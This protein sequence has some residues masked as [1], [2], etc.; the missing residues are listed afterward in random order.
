[1]GSRKRTRILQAGALLSEQ[2]ASVGLTLASNSIGQ[3]GK[4]AE[5]DYLGRQIGKARIGLCSVLG[6]SG[7]GFSIMCGHPRFP[8]SRDIRFVRHSKNLL[9]NS[10]RL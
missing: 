6:I 3:P 4:V 1:M 2:Y 5:T 9:S 7:H 8:I 10:L